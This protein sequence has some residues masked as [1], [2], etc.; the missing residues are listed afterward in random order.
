MTVK[1]ASLILY[2]PEYTKLIKALNIDDLRNR[3]PPKY[4]TF[5][6]KAGTNRHVAYWK[7][8]YLDMEYCDAQHGYVC[9]RSASTGFAAE[10]S[11]E[12][13]SLITPGCIDFNWAF[14][15]FW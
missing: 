7:K 4:Y 6:T 15:S 9:E 2:S 3:V 1:T 8:G 13:V 10:K 12:F 14:C 5:Y 11:G